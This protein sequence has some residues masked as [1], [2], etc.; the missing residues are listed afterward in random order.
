MKNMHDPATM[1]ELIQRINVLTPATQRQWGK[2]DVAQ[3]MAHLSNSL[4]VSTGDKV[5]KQ[6]FMG[7]IFG[8]I[9][10]KSVTS[11]KPLRQGVP[12]APGFLVVGSKDFNTEKQRL[13]TLMKRLS[14][15]DP[16]SLAT[17][18]H[19]FFGRMTPQEWNLVNYKHLDHHFRQFG[20]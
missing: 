18:T 13:I 14:A 8:K 11:E 19:P 9:A 2:M 1:E 6:A 12:T 16:A 3:M 17:K 10:K 20:A 15:A 7:M 4:E 5:Y